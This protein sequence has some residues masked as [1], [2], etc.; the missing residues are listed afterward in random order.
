MDKIISFSLWG[1]NPKYTV[2]AIRNAE[3]APFVYPGWITRFYVGTSVPD[4]IIYIL[5]EFDHVQIINK[6][7]PGDW[8][9]MFWRF[10]SSYDQD[11]SVSIFRDTDSRLNTREKEAV[12]EWMN[13]DKLFHIMR[14]H[15]YH[16]F[17]I[18]G[19]MWGV[20]NNN[21]INL[22]ELLDTFITNKANN[23]YGTDY[24]FLGNILYPLIKNNDC[25]VHD[26]FFDKKS[27]PNHREN[28]QFVGQVFDENEITVKEHL[29]ALKNYRN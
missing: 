13:S 4:K 9:G 15:P 18:L 20:K 27:F 28:H 12:E 21:K 16:N 3:L 2:G 19:G 14:D 26:E 17:P 11:V 29:D 6:E 10:E 23:Q 22:K 24:N 8:T 1:S 5:E 7:T 25:I